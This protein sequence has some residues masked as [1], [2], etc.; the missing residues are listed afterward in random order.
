MPQILSD[1]YDVV[2]NSFLL[3]A[4]RR[5]QHICFVLGQRAYF[6]AQE[7]GPWVALEGVAEIVCGRRSA[8]VI[9]MVE[10]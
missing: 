1:R 3:I 2:R 8:N 7:A 6:S 9:V 5:R 10:L 4:L